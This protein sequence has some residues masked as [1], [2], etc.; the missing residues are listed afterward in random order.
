MMY[1][2]TN[3]PL[4]HYSITPLVALIIFVLATSCDRL[5]GKPDEAARW[6]RPTEVR[7]FNQ[8]YAQSCS[9]CHGADGR[10][11]PARPLND[12]LYLALM[13]DDTLRQVI[14]Q[15][16]P[17]TAMPGFVQQQ[18]GNLTDEQIKVV[19]QGIRSRW[20]R[21]EEFQR[22]SLPAYEAGKDSKSGDVPRGLIVYQTYCTQC[23]DADGRG[24]PKGGSI[25][26]PNYLA[27]VSDQSLRTTV[28]VGR[29]DLGKPDW[30]DNVPGRSMS[31]Q[32]ISDVVAWIASHRR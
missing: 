14:A 9:G 29:S 2:K 13:N 17:K 11:G 20:A 27:L 10:L 26:D 3:T 15:G 30:R 5:P 12:P 28:I 24:V 18:G 25:L 16:V 7:D 1:L 19:V 22:A 21:S 23:H 31:L 8:L 6:K 4:L 32:E